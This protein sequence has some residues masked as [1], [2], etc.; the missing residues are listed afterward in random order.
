MKATTIILAAV[1][2]LTANVLF[3]S[4]DNLVPVANSTTVSM[5][6][7]A[8]VVPC[9]ADFE[10]AFIVDYTTLAPISPAEA[11]FEDLA[12]ETVS[13]LNL[14]PVTPANADFEEEADRNSLAPVVPAEADFE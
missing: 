1:L 6:T 12:Y 3:A 13:T 2:T 5:T 11:Q 4:N 7:L 9:E 8:P 14:A 10:D